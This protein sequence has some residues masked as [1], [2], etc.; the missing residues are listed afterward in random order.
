MP[1]RLL[2]SLRRALTTHPTKQEADAP[3][4]RPASVLVPLRPSGGELEFVFIQRSEALRHHPG[5]VAFP[6]GGREGAEDDLGCAL[7]EAQEE[8]G[9]EPRG[10]EVLGSL[11]S[12]FTPTGF[13]I[14]PFVGRISVDPA[15]LRPDPAEIARIFTLSLRELAAPGAYR[16]THLAPDQPLEFFV[17]GD[18]LVWGATA[19]ILRRVVEL[20]RGE[21]LKAE[22]PI[23]W[24]RIRF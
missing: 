7:R 3:G 20:A 11:E 2:D 9:L 24:D 14:S 12:C 6:G 17:C 8:V 1:E 22:G 16:K 4:Y 23:P 13:Q 15:T 18:E 10:V 5:Q 19:R 21:A